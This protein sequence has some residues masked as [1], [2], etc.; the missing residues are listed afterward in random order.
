[1]RRLFTVVSALATGVLAAGVARADQCK[2]VDTTIVTTFTT[3]APNES[4]FGLCTE[5]T[6]ASGL[7][8]GTTRFAVQ[9]MTGTDTSV[10]YTGVLTITTRSGTVQIR[11][12]GVLNPLTGQ[13]TEIEQVIGG[14][15]RFK[16]L[17]GLLVSQ[18]MQTAT[19]F[20]GTLVGTLCHFNEGHHGK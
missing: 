13:F 16:H 20:S 7:L 18:G 9:T 8:A 14:T 6:V 4:P 10:M 5:G 11:D 15:G 1:M 19:G 17:A 12:S 3:C 2:A